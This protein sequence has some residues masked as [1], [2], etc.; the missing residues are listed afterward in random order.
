MEAGLGTRQ[1]PYAVG[2]LFAG[3]QSHPLCEVATA[4][5][6]DTTLA[7]LWRQLENLV[8]SPSG[9]ERASSLKKL[10]L[11][12]DIRAQLATQ[13]SVFLHCRASNVRGDIDLRPLNVIKADHG[14]SSLPKP[15][16]GPPISCVIVVTSATWLSTGRDRPH[17]M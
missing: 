8:E 6:H 3:G 10:K 12:V 7:L 5:A 1:W 13:G 4:D 16:K 2:C 9:L 14:T 17:N 11:E 15:T